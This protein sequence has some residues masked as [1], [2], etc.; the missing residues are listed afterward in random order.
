[1]PEI[2]GF[3]HGMTLP[4]TWELYGATIKEA[5]QNSRHIRN[6]VII[7]IATILYYFLFVKIQ[8]AVV[9]HFLFAFI[10]TSVLMEFWEFLMGSF[11]IV[12]LFNIYTIIHLCIA[13]TAQGLV[14]LQRK[15]SDK[16]A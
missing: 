7:L 10:L 16:K 9:K 11:S 1:M 6:G 12:E 15:I 5:V 4:L 13:L 14:L 2:I 8:T 3:F